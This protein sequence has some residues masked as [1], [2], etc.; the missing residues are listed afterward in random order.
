MENRGNNNLAGV[1]FMA[2]AWA[3][4]QAVLDGGSRIEQVKAI[5]EA[6]PELSLGMAV[7]IHHALTM[8][9]P[10]IPDSFSASILDACKYLSWEAAND[11]RITLV[12]NSGLSFADVSTV[13]LYSMHVLAKGTPQVH[14]IIYTAMS[15]PDIYYFT[16]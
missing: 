16:G 13:P 10:P 3:I 4:K 14:V 2:R 1:N 9:K 8:E 7:L 11:A 15:S 5:R 6:C 12:K